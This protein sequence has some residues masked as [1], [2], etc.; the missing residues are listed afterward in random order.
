MWSQLPQSVLAEQQRNHLK[1]QIFFPVL[2]LLPA[3]S[4]HRIFPQG[5]FPLLRTIRLLDFFTI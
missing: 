4:K 5:Q 2:I 1:T 3:K